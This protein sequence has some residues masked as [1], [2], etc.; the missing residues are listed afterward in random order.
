MI[1]VTEEVPPMWICAV[2]RGKATSMTGPHR[3][4]KAFNIGSGLE[5]AKSFSSLSVNDVSVYTRPYTASSSL[6]M[7]ASREHSPARSF[8]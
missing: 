6:P 1:K 3:S 7:T 5:L 2:N 8:S 4:G